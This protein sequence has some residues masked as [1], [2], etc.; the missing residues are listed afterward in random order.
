MAPDLVHAILSKIRATWTVANDVEITMEANP[1][2][3]EFGR[4]QGYKDAGVERV[5]I[6]VQALNDADLKALGRLHSVHEAKSAIELAQTIFDRVSFDLIYARQDQSLAQWQAELS[7]ALAMA[8]GHLSLYQLTIE[9][10]TAF[11]DRFRRGL[12]RGLP[13]ENLGADMYL[14]TQDMTALAGYHSYEVSNY[15]KY[16]QESRHNCMYWNAG[17]YIGIGPGAHGRLTL[18]SVRYATEAAASPIAWLS[19]VERAGTFEQREKVTPKEQGLEYLMMG[20]RRDVGIDVER[21]ARLSGSPIS[22]PKLDELRDI[23]VIEIAEGRLSATGQGRLVLNA[24][25]ERLI[26]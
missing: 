5:S 26:D 24:V 22:Q 21:F 9:D 15:A 19:G 20:L 16:G 2:S 17:D 11:G 1:S 6:G 4:F 18:S 13:D 7:E 14:A 10:G 25:I 12:L 8:S 23:G 3:V